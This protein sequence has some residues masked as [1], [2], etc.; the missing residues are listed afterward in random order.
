MCQVTGL[1]NC[2]L[3]SQKTIHCFVFLV[4]L[5]QGGKVTIPLFSGSDYIRTALFQLKCAGRS[6][7]SYNMQCLSKKQALQQ[8]EEV[9]EHA[10]ALW[11]ILPK[12]TMG[13]LTDCPS[14]TC[15]W[16]Q[17]TPHWG[18][19]SCDLKHDSW[20]SLL[21]PLAFPP[22]S[23]HLLISYPPTGQ[24]TPCKWAVSTRN[25]TYTPAPTFLTSCQGTSNPPVMQSIW[26]PWKW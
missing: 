5:T 21:A 4:P 10:S 16:T 6:F 9:R 22:I 2:S 25:H 26:I 17:I 1:K 24:L 18:L 23:S 12:R 19:R 11:K 8:Q 3:S 15:T 7:S 14:L 13:S 20:A